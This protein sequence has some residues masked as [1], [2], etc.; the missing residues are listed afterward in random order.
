MISVLLILLVVCVASVAQ[1]ETVISGVSPQMGV[2]FGPITLYSSF[3]H[4]IVPAEGM[5]YVISGIK[6]GDVVTVTVDTWE[7]TSTT[8]SPIV[9]TYVSN[10]GP[11]SFNIPPLQR[12]DYVLNVQSVNGVLSEILMRA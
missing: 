11:E 6:A 4:I 8:E 9:F 5:P 2:T 3:E 10:G 12:G 7:H 1:A